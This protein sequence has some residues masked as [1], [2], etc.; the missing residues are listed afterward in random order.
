MITFLQ[1]HNIFFSDAKTLVCPVNTVG[2]MGNGLA[3][4]FRDRIPGLY[5]AYQKACRNGIFQKEGYFLYETQY[6][7]KILCFPTKRHWK[8]DS[9]IRYIKEGLQKLVET[10]KERGIT[11][12][13]FPPVGCG[14]G[15]LV[16]EEVKPILIEYLTDTDME[17]T[18]IEPNGYW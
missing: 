9:H 17:V 4:A 11:S 18:V 8:K 16:W 6:G 7:K 12:I 3:R 14:K 2:V 13:V 10:Y 5:D 1:G 15:N